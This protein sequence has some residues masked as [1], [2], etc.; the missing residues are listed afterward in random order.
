MDVVVRGDCDC[1]QVGKTIILP[2][3]HKGNLATGHKIIKMQW[4]Y[5]DGLDTQIYFLPSHVTQSGQK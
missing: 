1:S 5:V 3:S 2:S 4:L